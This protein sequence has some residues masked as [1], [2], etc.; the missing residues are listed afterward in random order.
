MRATPSYLVW[1]FLTSFNNKW[2]E[3]NFE[4]WR[5]LV[6]PFSFPFSSVLGITLPSLMGDP[7]DFCACI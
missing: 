3:V 1:L 2:L 7:L 5:D 4:F 6:R